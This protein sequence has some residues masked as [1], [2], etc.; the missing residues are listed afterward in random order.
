MAE[1]VLRLSGENSYFKVEVEMGN[2]FEENK[3][4]VMKRY[5]EIES[6]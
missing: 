2:I 5:E 3:E 6:L 1:C 4:M